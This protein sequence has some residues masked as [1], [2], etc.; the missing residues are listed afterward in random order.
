[1]PDWKIWTKAVGIEDINLDH[2]PHFTI[3]SMAIEAAINGNGVALVSHHAVAEDL[4]A[5]RLVKPF[6]LALPAD[7][8]YWLVCPHE[9][10]RRAK[11]KAFCDWLLEEAAEDSM[12][13]VKG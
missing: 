5:G 12:A 9:Y 4:K 6:D 8:S 3:E 10:L 11:V 7:F 1:M 13:M 2:G